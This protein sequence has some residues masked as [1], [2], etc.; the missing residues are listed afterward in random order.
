MKEVLYERLF[1]PVIFGALIFSPVLCNLFSSENYSKAEAAEIPQ[2]ETLVETPEEK[3]S[4]PVMETVLA[5]ATLYE[6]EGTTRT[7]TAY[8]SMPSQTDGSPCSA[9]RGHNI[10]EMWDQGYN[11]CASNAFVIG[12][13]LRIDHLGDC[14]VLDRMNNR[15]PNRIDW[16]AGYDKD[17]LDDYQLGDSCPNWQRALTMKQILFAKPIGHIDI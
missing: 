14:I 16:Y 1:V 9:A 5:Q 6:K 17:C 11:I 4:V 8:T 10:C 7:I 12:T 15:F 13:I 3:E 2:E